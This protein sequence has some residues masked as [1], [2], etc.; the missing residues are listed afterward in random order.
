MAILNILDI[1]ASR[2]SLRIKL[3][4]FGNAYVL[5]SS[6]NYTFK[7]GQH[8]DALIIFHYKWQTLT[9]NW[10]LTKKKRGWIQKKKFNRNEHYQHWNNPAWIPWHKLIW[11]HNEKLIIIP[12]QI[13]NLFLLHHTNMFRYLKMQSKFIFIFSSFWQWILENL[14][15]GRL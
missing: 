12:G 9:I 10:S 6:D 3:D 8:Y 14:L 2:W 13:W 15:P 11:H 4:N 1:T 5:L 7:I